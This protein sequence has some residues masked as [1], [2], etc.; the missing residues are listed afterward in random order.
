MRQTYRLVSCQSDCNL[1]TNSDIANVIGHMIRSGDNAQQPQVTLLNVHHVCRAVSQERG[2]YKYISLLAEYMCVGSALC[3]D[4]TATEQ[5]E[6]GC[7]NGNW[8]NNVQGSTTN[9][10]TRNPTATFSTTLREDCGFCFS[11]ELAPTVGVPVAN[12]PDDDHHCVG[13]YHSIQHIEIVNTKL[14]VSSSSSTMVYAHISPHA[15]HIQVVTHHVK[16]S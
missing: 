12:A 5:F 7:L 8:S 15:I 14:C 16:V 4:G 3:P 10:R 11:P 6:T 1:P 9:T 13:E 2:R